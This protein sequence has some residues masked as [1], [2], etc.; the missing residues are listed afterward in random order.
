MKVKL[1]FET[2]FFLNLIK[3]IQFDALSTIFYGENFIIKKIT[4]DIMF[5]TLSKYSQVLLGL[6][7]SFFSLL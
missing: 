6:K 4:L 2:V 7:E 1:E 3:N 5:R